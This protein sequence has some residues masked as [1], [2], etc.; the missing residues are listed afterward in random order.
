M[1]T[2]TNGTM[3]SSN[4]GTAVIRQLPP[5]RVNSSARASISARITLGVS[6]TRSAITPRVSSWTK[7]KASSMDG[8]VS[9]AQKNF[10]ESRLKSTGYTAITALAPAARAPCTALMPTPPVPT[11][12]TTSPTCVPTPTVPEPHPVVTPQDTSDAASS[13]IDSSSLITHSSG[14]TEYS[15]NVPSWHMAVKSSSPTWRRR[16][17]SMDSLV[18]MWAPLSQRYVI[19]DT[20]HRHFPHA[21]MNENDT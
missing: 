1:T 11:M 12:T 17:P 16:A 20:H 14:R 18:S 15:A 5:L 4:F 3:L 9:V 6:T 8:L 7:P 2:R 19:P 10:A 13:G 21:A